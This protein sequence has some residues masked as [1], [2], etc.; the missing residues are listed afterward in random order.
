VLVVVALA[1]AIGDGGDGPIVPVAA[2][3]AAVIAFGFV[4][5]RSQHPR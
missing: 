4:A 5:W 2:V 1:L 3:V